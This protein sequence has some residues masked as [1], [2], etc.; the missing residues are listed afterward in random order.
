MLS[1]VSVCMYTHICK[2]AFA[3]GVHVEARGWDQVSLPL[4][5][6][7]FVTESHIELGGN[8]VAKLRS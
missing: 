2:G 7:F 1:V 3:M 4:S 5:T 8:Q 6:L